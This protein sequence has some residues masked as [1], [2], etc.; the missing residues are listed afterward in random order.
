MANVEK[1]ADWTDEQ[2][3]A[4]FGSPDDTQVYVQFSTDGIVD[5]PE[6]G[7]D[8]DVGDAEQVAP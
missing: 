8:F 5:V 6:A 1:P 7:D 4:Y 2:W 3:D